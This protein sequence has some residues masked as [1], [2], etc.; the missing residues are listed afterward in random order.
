MQFH[1]NLNKDKETFGNSRPNRYQGRLDPN[2]LRSINFQI[3]KIAGK[4]K[5][6]FFHSILFSYYLFMVFRFFS[7]VPFILF[8]FIC[9]SQ[10]SKP[11]HS[12]S[13]ICTPNCKLCRSLQ[14][15]QKTSLESC[16]N[17]AVLVLTVILWRCRFTRFERLHDHV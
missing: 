14:N 1:A 9:I 7:F 11:V 2:W 5:V 3:V 10:I 4:N 8:S 17:E 16:L 15:I 12:F 6:C 13:F